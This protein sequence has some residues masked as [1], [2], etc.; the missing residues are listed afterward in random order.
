MRH[1]AALF[2]ALVLGGCGPM[3]VLGERYTER[4]DGF[5]YD[6]FRGR[7]YGLKRTDGAGG[8]LLVE[9]R[10][11]KNCRMPPTDGMKRMGITALYVEDS[12]SG[13]P[14]LVAELGKVAGGDE[15]VRCIG[16]LREEASIVLVCP[17]PVG[18]N[19]LLEPRKP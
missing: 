15:P 14:K 18:Y 8:E 3:L 5:A 4:C 11:A 9:L 6:E 10:I 13:R 1:A 7:S 16:R 12:R 17:D 19:I 2:L